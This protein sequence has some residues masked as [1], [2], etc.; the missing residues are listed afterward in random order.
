[1]KVD[2]RNYVFAPGLPP[3]RVTFRFF[4]IKIAKEDIS[5]RDTLFNGQSGY[6]MKLLSLRLQL[7]LSSEHDAHKTVKARLRPWLSGKNPQC[8]FRCPLHPGGNPGANL[9]SI[10]HR[11][12]PILLAFVW[13]LTK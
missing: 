6:E 12:H 7:Q 11:C 2:S 4:F 13:G 5:S 9:E 3:T 10:Y 1:M 8:F